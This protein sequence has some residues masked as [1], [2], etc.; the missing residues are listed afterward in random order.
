VVLLATLVFLLA[1]AVMVY[2]VRDAR[3]RGR[4]EILRQVEQQTR[5][6]REFWLEFYAGKREVEAME[7]AEMAEAAKCGKPVPISLPLTIR[8]HLPPLEKKELKTFNHEAA[9]AFYPRELNP[10]E[11]GS[12]DSLASS[13]S[14][15]Q[16]Q[17]QPLA[18]V[19][20]VHATRQQQAVMAEAHAAPKP[21]QAVVAK[22]PAALEL[23]QQHQQQEQQQ[24][25]VAEVHA[26]PKPHQQ[27]VATNGMASEAEVMPR[28]SLAA[29]GIRARL[30]QIFE[31]RITQSPPKTTAP[32]Q[33]QKQPE[34]I[35]A[36]LVFDHVAPRQTA[37]IKRP[38]T[39]TRRAPPPPPL[40]KPE[41]GGHSACYT[42]ATLPRRCQASVVAGS[43]QAATNNARGAGE[44][45]KQAPTLPRRTSSLRR[46]RSMP[47]KAG[48]RRD[49]PTQFLDANNLWDEEENFV[50]YV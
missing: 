30:E 44:T 21:Q 33:Q 29:D 22:V 10:F 3:H 15:Y 1:A 28:Y 27:V 41:A 40:P 23:R 19:A 42:T 14:A 24:A 25:V 39:K 50:S 9:A 17:Q 16:Q 8:H 37:T 32:E 35:Y 49:L 18:V 31:P 2:L 7:A 36:S 46:S 34:I 43:A 47:M 13:S 11:N 45:H 12:S 5:E 20:K 48:S 4:E 6:G 38:S 26:A